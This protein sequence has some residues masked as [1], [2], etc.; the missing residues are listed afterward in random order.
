VTAD[1][2][3]PGAAPL[4]ALEGVGPARA[5]RLG[6][7]GL[8]SV[9]DLLCLLP[10]RLERTGARSD[11]RT[12]AGLA[13]EEVALVGTLRGLRLFRAGWRRSVLSLDLVDEAG[14]L[15]ALFFNQPWLFERLRALAA[16]GTR[17]ELIGRV[18]STKQGPAL[19]APKL[20]EEPPATRVSELV[21]V[22][23]AVEGLGQELLRRLLADGLARF[24]APRE[25]LPSAV[26]R[27]LA[28]PSLEAAVRVLHVPPD[29]EHFRQARRRLVFERLLELQARLLEG[30]ARDEQRRARVVE[31]DGPTRAA[32]LGALP[33]TPT[34]GQQ[35]VLQEILADLARARPMRR[36]LQG[37]VGSGKTLVALAACAAVARAGGQ[38]A[39]MAPTEL[40]AE[41]H[42]L[43]LA[44]HLAR[45]GLEAALVTGSL[46]APARRR[47]VA[48]LSEGRAALA[49][50][51]HALFSPDVRFARLDLVVIDEQQRF[52]VA[53]KRALLEKGA[54]VHALLMTATPIPR[55]LALC[56]YGDLETSLLAERPPGRAE[57]VTQVVPS[58]G[59]AA[60][61]AFLVERAR[62]G[63]RIYWVCPRIDDEVEDG[64]E[65]K[66]QVA[67]ATR[68]LQELARGPLAPFG[69]E[70]LHGRL[71]PEQRARAIERFRQGAAQ[72]LVG[73]SIVEV[74]VDV[75]EA[76]AIVIEGAERF[77]LAQLH[78]LRGRV[79]RSSRPSTCFLVAT[80][81]DGERLAFLARSSSGFEIAEEDLRRRGMGD[82]AGLRQAGENLEG[83]CDEDLEHELVRAA[84]ELVRTDA[85]LA[86]HYLGAAA[87]AALV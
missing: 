23:P 44:P 41:Q 43:G 54:D 65:S 35:R 8:T 72:V 33:F 13:G 74:G 5:A 55:T 10:R 69:L 12:A 11:T 42:Q 68:A 62:A 14:A 15:R 77:G 79:G 9:R 50:G 51:T 36:L 70:P 25:P 20:V 87:R 34:A 86:R 59:R 83:L 57:V 3:D 53:Q 75:P 37:E 80:G 19:L 18:G 22:Y 29:E 71:R 45:L 39:L 56:F 26:L 66:D 78:Q 47:A 85:T 61:L 52:G 84:R 6:A 21:P 17:V 4:T 38:A 27:A 28:L 30:H 64:R 1:T 49:I 63:E 60:L 2:E 40:L 7:L 31:L 24:G 32:L 76:T 48:A 58:D 46:T 16:A 73:T 81:G 82:L 67:S